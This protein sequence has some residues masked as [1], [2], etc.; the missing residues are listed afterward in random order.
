MLL[1]L[2]ALALADDA[3][4]ANVA[5][6]G[7]T[8]VAE[9][10]DNIAVTTNPGALGLS[11][12]YDILGNFI[13]GP[14][15]DLRWGVVAVD[16]STNDRIA[17]GFAYWGQRTNPPFLPSELPGWAPTGT[18]PTNIKRTHDLS[19]SLAAPFLD[20][21]LSLGL[22]GTMSIFNNDHSGTGV[23]GNMIFG[24]AARP[25]D[26]VSFGFAA[27]D[28][29]P[30]PVQD[31]RPAQLTLGSVVGDPTRFIGSVE[32]AWR[33]E[34]VIGHAFDARA[35][36]EGVIKEAVH[37]RGG[38][39]WAGNFDVH[40]V[41]W[42]FG[43]GSKAGRLDYAMRIPVVPGLRFGQISHVISL[44]LF[45]KAFREEDEFNDF[46]PFNRPSQS[47]NRPSRNRPQRPQRPP[48]NTPNVPPP[49][50]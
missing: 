24:A 8:S 37:L 27:R 35:G 17:F 45:T 31:D 33:A 10:A 28:V 44:V 12:R 43:L 41:S 48:P 11:E 34:G 30:I 26:L 22:G 5:G 16:S 36:L 42:G 50:R 13:G 3:V 39:D 18:E 40:R 6:R 1:L 29:L 20:R 9:A 25:H 46:G 47:A 4:P 19:F 14:G 7:G 38:W 23:T 15:T 21:R 49:P 2:A 32:G